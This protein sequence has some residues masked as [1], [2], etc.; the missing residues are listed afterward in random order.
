MGNYVCLV[1]V[2]D[3]VAHKLPNSRGTL[4]PPMPPANIYFTFYVMPCCQ[5][6]KRN[7]LLVLCVVH[8]MVGV[9][10]MPSSSLWVLGIAYLV[11][12]LL[13]LKLPTCISCWGALRP[14]IPLRQHLSYVLHAIVLNTKANRAAGQNPF[15]CWDG[16]WHG[17]RCIH[18]IF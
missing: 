7:G 2:V 9:A 18:A 11:Y 14:P 4:R 16:L 3:V 17:W 5:I 6:R 10:C 12:T 13:L 1:V 8:G 15:H